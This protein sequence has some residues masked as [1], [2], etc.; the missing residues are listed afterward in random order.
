M[1]NQN[2]FFKSAQ[3]KIALSA[4]QGKPLSLTY[5]EIVALNE[6]IKDLVLVPVF[7]MDDPDLNEKLKKHMEERNQT[8]K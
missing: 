7:R 8:S 3:Q 5:N 6:A 4:Q 2:D 1:S